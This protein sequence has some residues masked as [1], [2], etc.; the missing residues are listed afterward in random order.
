MFYA[1]NVLVAEAPELRELLRHEQLG[2]ADGGE[3]GV[4]HALVRDHAG[5]VQVLLEITD[6]L[7]EFER[8][9]LKQLEEGEK[10]GEMLNSFELLF[11][12]TEI[13]IKTLI[14]PVLTY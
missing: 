10:R 1:H 4:A 3:D 7:L 11:P 14:S 5:R 6:A 2:L 13:D 8:L 12:V 9:V